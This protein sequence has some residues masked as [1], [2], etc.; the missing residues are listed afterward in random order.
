MIQRSL[1]FAIFA[2]LAVSASV[3]VIEGIGASGFLQSI[4]IYA[5]SFSM[6]S[7]VYLVRK[8]RINDAAI[9]DGVMKGMAKVLYYRS[10]KTPL[11]KAI[12]KAAKSSSNPLSSRIL[13][14]TSRRI[15][16]GGDLFDSLISSSRKYGLEA[17]IKKYL[18]GPDSTVSESVMLYENRKASEIAHKG[19]LASRYATIGMFVSTVAPSFIIFS[20]LG[21]LMISQAN[22]SLYLL[23]T[24]LIAA[25]PASYS[26]ISLFSARSLN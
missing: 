4:P 5:V 18:K 3:S 25:I 22:S 2:S 13:M 19:A 9:I 16:M 1:I 6:I 15:M 10:A 11:A 14:E 23:S 7:Y 24:F 12:E 21:G 20:F 26:L 8:R 17:Q